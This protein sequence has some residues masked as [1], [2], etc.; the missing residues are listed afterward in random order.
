MEPDQNSYENN[1]WRKPGI[2]QQVSQ[3]LGVPKG[4]VMFEHTRKPLSQPPKGGIAHSMKGKPGR[5]RTFRKKPTQ[6]PI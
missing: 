1:P 2:A 6:M 3:D 5:V 4:T